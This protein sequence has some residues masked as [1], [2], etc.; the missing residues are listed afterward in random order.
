MTGSVRPWASQGRCVGL[1]ALDAPPPIAEDVSTTQLYTELEP[2]ELA[3][4][5]AEASPIADLIRRA[6]LVA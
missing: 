6:G 1:L 5:H 3:A 4:L 2:D